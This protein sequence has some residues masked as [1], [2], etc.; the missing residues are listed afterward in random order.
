MSRMVKSGGRRARRCSVRSSGGGGSARPGGGQVRGCRGPR[1]GSDG[2][3]LRNWVAR[4]RADRRRASP[5]AHDGRARGAGPSAPGDPQLRLERDV[6]KKR[7]PSSPRRTGKVRVRPDGEGRRTVATLCPRPQDLPQR[8]L[9][10]A[11]ASRFGARAE[12]SAVACAGAR[13]VRCQPS[14]LWKSPCV[15]DL[16]EEGLRVSRKRLCV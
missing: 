2:V 5:V 8:L 13:L 6:L 9:R 7:R 15:E 4:A 11:R 3:A 16:V 10:V 14:T 12:G 1:S